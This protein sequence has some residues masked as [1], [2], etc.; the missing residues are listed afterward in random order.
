MELVC[1]CYY[2]ARQ[3]EASAEN[4]TNGLPVLEFVH[5]LV[6]GRVRC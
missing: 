2:F 1:L 6:K 3:L 4:L 5:L